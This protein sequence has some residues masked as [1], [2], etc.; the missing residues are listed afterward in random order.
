VSPRKPSATVDDL[1]AAFGAASHAKLAPGIGAPEDNIRGPFEELFGSLSLL[2]GVNVTTIGEATLSDERVRPDFA[3]LVGKDPLPVGFVELKAPGLGSDTSRFGTGHNK[4]QW[5]RLRALPNLIYTDGNSWRLYRSGEPTR[6]ATLRGAIQNAPELADDGH[7]LALVSDFLEWTPRPPKGIDDLVE[8]TA[9]LCALLRAEV[10]E[11]LP[12]SPSLTALATDWRHLLFPNASDEKFADGY[13]QAVTFGLL[14]ARA[15]NVDFS[16]RSLHDIA[17]ALGK[18][19]SLMGRALSVLTDPQLLGELRTSVQTLTRV[20]SVVDWKVLRKA[21]G[22]EPWLHF[23]EDFLAAYDPKLRKATGSYYTPAPVVEC[24]TRIT[25]DVL[26]T[27]LHKDDGLAAD[28]VT[29]VDPAMGTGTFLLEV[30][31]SIASTVEQTQGP[32]AVRARLRKAAN[33]IVGFELQAGPYAVAELRTLATFDRHKAD[34]PPDGLRL[35][36]TDTLDDPYVEDVRLGAVYEPIARSRREAN[37]V[38]KDVPVLV[39]LGNPPYGAKAKGLGGWVEQ[40]NPKA[41]QAALMEDFREP[42]AGRYE[43]ALKNLYVYFWRWALWKA[44]EAHPEHPHGVVAFIT[45]SGWLQGKGFAGMRRYLRRSCDHVWIIDLGGEG[46][47]GRRSENVF[48]IQVPVAITI[49]IRNGSRAGS[50]ADIDILELTGTREEKFAA[51]SAVDLRSQWTRTQGSGADAIVAPNTSAWPTY[52]DITQLFP[53]VAP[54]CKPNRTWVYAPEPEVLARRWS[55]V[56]RAKGQARSKMFR[57]S[58]DANLDRVVAPFRGFPRRSA[59]KD[60]SGPAPD[61]IRVSFRTLDR[62]WAL[63]DSRLYHGP[64]P[65]L[66][67]ARSDAQVHISFNP[68]PASG[69]ATTFAPY[70]PDMAHFQGNANAGGNVLPLWRDADATKANV[71]PGLLRYLSIA[72]GYE[73]SPADLLAFVACMTSHPGYTERFF[74]DFAE[75]GVRVPLT[76][77]GDLFVRCRDTGAHVVW[78]YCYGERFA[79]S[80]EGR[81]ARTPRVPSDRAPKIV[82]PIPDSEAEMPSEVSYDPQTQTIHIGSGAVAPVSEAVWHFDVS[83]YAVVHRWIAKRLRDPEGRRT[84]PLDSIVAKSWTAD[85]ST[86]LLNLLH[87]VTL[88]T[89]IAPT[90]AALLDEVLEGQLVTV[91]ALTIAGVLPPDQHATRPPAPADSPETLFGTDAV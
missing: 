24:M 65:R 51:L 15:E 81:P 73:V 89:E 82:T 34:P 54:G 69:P 88:L 70:V 57:E 23:Y 66:W 3:V 71:T 33:R 44:F 60:E 61:P 49:A 16:T 38:K 25:D 12:A 55:E 84:S 31:E 58:R 68:R 29:I 53:W 56:V 30:I 21:K 14:L 35:Y 45:S 13:A 7:L 76:A 4:R 46:R 50:E 63:P 39:V 27:H 26:R 52:P 2:H 18:R 6:V 47:G 67:D 90:Q 77:D 91:E 11:L 1:L 75:A 78:L 41:K 9:G 43:Y 74:A 42:G 5:E 8:K 87:V 64:S 85:T 22:K 32:G 28:E 62:Q 10:L 40:G 20:C 86:E 59:F 17:D 48:D 83:G 36:V 79:D 37:K 72:Y 19:H 80:T